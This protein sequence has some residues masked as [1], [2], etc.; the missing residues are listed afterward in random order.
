MPIRYTP[1]SADLTAYQELQPDL[2]RGGEAWLKDMDSVVKPLTGGE[3]EAGLLYLVGPMP[4][5]SYQS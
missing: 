3:D 4:W 5:M 2:E 1:D